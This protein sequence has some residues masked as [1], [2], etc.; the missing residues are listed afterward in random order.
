MTLFPPGTAEE[1]GGR[2]L[3]RDR[4]KFGFYTVPGI[5]AR[6]AGEISYEKR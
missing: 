1:K 2:G 3:E 6:F 5:D 4:C